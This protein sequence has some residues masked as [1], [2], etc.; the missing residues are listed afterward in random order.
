M[1]KTNRKW[2][3]NHIFVTYART[4]CAAYGVRDV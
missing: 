1:Y 3:K 2:Q 4:G